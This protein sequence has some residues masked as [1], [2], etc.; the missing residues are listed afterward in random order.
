MR[1]SAL[2]AMMLAAVMLLSGC[3]LVEKDL[4]VDNATEIIKFTDK[5]GDTY[6]HTK[7]EINAEV[8]E[9][10]DYMSYLYNM[11]GMA[12]DP[13]DKSNIAD[14]Q[15]E[16]IDY[17]LESDVKASKAKELGLDQ[18]TEEEEKELQDA[19][20]SSWQTYKDYVKTMY[21]SSTELE[22]D[23]LEQAIADKCAELGYSREEVEKSERKSKIEDKLG[24]QIRA[25][26]TE[27]DV[28]ED[29]IKFDFDSKVE[30]A[31][32]EYESDL[33][34]YGKA[35]NGG[36][37]VYYRPEGYRMVKQILVKYQDADKAVIDD[38]TS[39][40]STAASQV[41]SAVSTLRSLGYDDPTVLTEFV[42]VTLEEPEAVASDLGVLT[43]ATVS[44]LQTEFAEDVPEEAQEQT[45]LMVQ[46]QAEADFYQKQLNAATE[47]ALAKIAPAADEI[48][49][50]LTDENWDAVMAEKTADPGMQ[51]DSETAKNGYAVC[52]A[53]S[54]MD[55][56]FTNA[57][58][59]L[60]KPGDVSEKAA[61]MYGYYIVK[62]VSDVQAGAV[63]LDSVH[64]GILN[65]LLE[66]KKDAHFDEELAKW[67]E[68]VNARIDKNALS[69]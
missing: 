47:A 18:F 39:K 64:E 30:E 4:E 10:L 66:E 7:G 5:A 3:A 8:K 61:G 41:N 2:I 40:Q 56:A 19:V 27:N 55:E 38:L 44:D 20:D 14:A 36:E 65:E 17:L 31:K 62:Y 22:G 34:A 23:A 13:T 11:Y 1:K 24:E 9:Q 51:G 63:E 16:V 12:Y 52:E 42:K 33:S 28:S 57:A 32:S 68:A 26:I 53:M 45:K 29:E 54:G 58:M 37:T 15:S 48:I 25:E 60:E 67:T 69:D 35:V 43:V 59:A 46:A 49:A 50:S 6:V 21:Y